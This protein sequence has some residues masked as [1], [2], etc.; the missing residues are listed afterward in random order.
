[1]VVAKAKERLKCMMSHR[2]L[3][4]KDASER[5]YC[6]DFAE[7]EAAA[8]RMAKKDR[9]KKK[10]AAPIDAQVSDGNRAA[11]QPRFTRIPSVHEISGVFA[12]TDSPPLPSR[13]DRF[14]SLR[15]ASSKYPRV[16]LEQAQASKVCRFHYCGK[17]QNRVPSISGTISERRPTLPTMDGPPPMRSRVTITFPQ[18]HSGGGHVH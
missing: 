12:F 18:D 1:M 4:H 3:E 8:A 13:L 9:R 7:A 14:Y 5:A 2:H 10:A 6:D 15:S 11:S 16:G 17:S